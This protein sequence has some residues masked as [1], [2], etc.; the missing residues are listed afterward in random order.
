[1]SQHSE[2]E[3]IDASTTN[4]GLCTSPLNKFV[5]N[6]A[7]TRVLLDLCKD[8]Y[9]ALTSAR[10]NTN[11]YKQMAAEFSNTFNIVPP[12]TGYQI[13]S[14]ISN[15]RKQFRREKLQVGSSGGA[16][17][18]W[19]PYDIVA[20]IIGGEASLDN[21]LL[22]QSQN[23]S[24][25]DF[26]DGQI[27]T[28]EDGKETVSILNTEALDD[29]SDVQSIVTIPDEEPTQSTS[30]CNKRRSS[31]DEKTLNKIAKTEPG[32][33]G[34]GK[35]YWKN[36]ES[37]LAVLRLRRRTLIND[38]SITHPFSYLDLASFKLNQQGYLIERKVWVRPKSSQ[39][40]NEIFTQMEECEFKEHFRV[41]R[42][43][44]NFLVNKLHPHLGKTTKTMREP[45]SV[46]KRV[47]VALHYLASCEE[48]R[49]V[50]SLFGIGKSTANLIVHEFINAVN[51]ILLP[52]YVKFPL[53][54]ENLNKHSRDFEAILGFP[55]CVE[56]Q[57]C[58][59]RQSIPFHLYKCWIAL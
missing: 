51:D 9:N 52:K 28:M 31:D 54:V 30:G 55:Q 14:K 50:S 38:E 23:F 48:Y 16:P 10:R 49:V 17:S 40:F 47:A 19:W 1:M 27:A 58:R 3:C 20:K 6:M 25:Q 32:D 35:S 5:W 37:V 8:N 2:K 7:N 36:M 21:D 39:W 22:S 34:K 26:Q 53:S 42:N 41:N 43:T 24:T 29:T 57:E 46:V 13:Q 11:I 59:C 56:N 12:L 18:K 44:F 45:I 33:I 4:I 15:L